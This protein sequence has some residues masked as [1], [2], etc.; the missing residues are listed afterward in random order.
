MRH[1]RTEDWLSMAQ[2]HVAEGEAHVARQE[3]LIAG[4]DRDGHTELA[5]EARALLTT[6]ETS[7]RLMRAD[8]SRI[9]NEPRRSG[10]E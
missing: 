8:L 5:A 4:L 3:T 7:L 6:L 10:P 2:R 9:E 1:R